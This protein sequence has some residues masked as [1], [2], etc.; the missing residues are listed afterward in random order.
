MEINLFNSFEEKYEIF[1]KELEKIINDEKVQL[2][3]NDIYYVIN[4]SY[5]RHSI[6]QYY[7]NITFSKEYIKFIDN[8]FSLIKCLKNESNYK[9]INRDLLEI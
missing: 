4:N 6:L 8:F 5:L 2:D 7:R 9:L 3:N 1:K